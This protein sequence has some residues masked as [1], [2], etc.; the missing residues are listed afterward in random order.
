MVKRARPYRILVEGDLPPDMAARCAEVW[1]DIRIAA[2]HASAPIPNM[3]KK[4]QGND[5]AVVQ[6][7]NDVAREGTASTP[8]TP[9]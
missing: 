8:S 7:P 1:R 2:L 4:R 9:L 5:S 6:E 3:P